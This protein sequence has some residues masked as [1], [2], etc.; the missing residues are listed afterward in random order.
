MGLKQSR[1]NFF[2]DGEGGVKLA[3]NSMT[4]A[5]AEIEPDKWPMV[6]AF[7]ENPNR[8]PENETERDLLENLKYGGFLIDED[9]DEIAYLKVMNRMT[10]F[11]KESLGLTICPTLNCNFACFYCYET[12]PK[13]VMSQDVQDRLVEFA[14]ER[15]ESAKSFQ[16]TWYGG[17]PL[18]A[19]DVIESLSEKFIGHCEQKG[20]AYSAYLVT[21]GYLLT[22]DKSKRLSELGVQGAQITL[23]GPPDVHD[24]RRVLTNGGPTFWRIMENLKSAL[25]FID[26]ITVRVNVDKEN[27]DRALELLDVLEGEGLK[28]RVSIYFTPTSEYSEICSV[29]LRDRGFGEAE[30][31]EIVLGLLREAIIE[32]GW[33]IPV[34]PTTAYLS[35]C[36][37]E[38][39]NGF[40]ITQNGS[41]HKCWL[42]AF[43][44][45]E[46]CGNILDLSSLN[47]LIAHEN[48][49]KWIACEPF[50]IQLCQEC[51]QLPICM[52]ECSYR[53][54]KRQK[55]PLEYCPLSDLSLLRETILLTLE[56]DRRG[57]INNKEA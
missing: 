29:Y 30:Q 45:E 4:A 18:L 35:P 13:G 26:K 2:F 9:F 36:A 55:E 24:K 14:K 31:G 46:K 6:Q 44:P 34:M 42:Q 7:L 19:F 16:V 12:H 41:L 49:T 3:F 37:A 5:L 10:R 48:F 38:S 40:V 25:N 11:S 8:E 54:L 1:Y 56:R 15:L 43:K 39:K 17:E 52:G 51:R 20:I 22:P 47:N 21:N 27:R 57:L 33:D 53:S 23:D 28:G 50:D 32:K